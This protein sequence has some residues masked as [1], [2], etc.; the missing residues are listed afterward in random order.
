MKVK[1]KQAEINHL[2]KIIKKIITDKVEVEYS[3]G[4]HLFKKYYKGCKGK[5]PVSYDLMQNCNTTDFPPDVK[6]S[7][8]TTGL[9]FKKIFKYGDFIILDL[10][11]EKNIFEVGITFS[12]NVEDTI[13]SNINP[14]RL[15]DLCRIY[16]KDA[17][18]IIY[19]PDIEEGMEGYDMFVETF[20]HRS[21][22]NHETPI[23]KLNNAI[24]AFRLVQDKS[25]SEVYKGLAK[26]LVK[27]NQTLNSGFHAKQ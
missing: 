17:G 1:N 11:K 25:A 10:V 13:T 27:Y 15:L 4:E 6:I 3:V 8:Y 22:C 9:Q 14:L 7:F 20:C 23:E 24:E 12:F 16:A 21:K 18:F 2:S 26:E 5:Y 19:D